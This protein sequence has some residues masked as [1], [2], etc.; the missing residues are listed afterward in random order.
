MRLRISDIYKA[1]TLMLLCSLSSCIGTADIDRPISRQDGMP[2][3][4]IREGTDKA[5]GRVLLMYFE[6]YNNLSFSLEQNLEELEQGYVPE[7]GSKDVMIVYSHTSKSKYDWETP[8]R[9]VIYRLYKH[10]GRT[11]RDTLKTY[12]PSVISVRK[13]MVSDILSTVKQKFPADSYGMLVNS[14][15]TGWLPVHGSI[16]SMSIGAQYGPNH[17]AE[18]NIDVDDFAEAI[19]MR[20][21]YIIF[22]CCLMGG[23]ETTYSLREKA[24]Y[25]VASPTEVLSDGFDYYK[26]AEE[27]LTGPEIDLTSMCRSYYDKHAGG[28]GATI[29]LYDCSVMDELADKCAEVLRGKGEELK[30][31]RP[32]DVQSYNYSFSYHYDFRDIISKVSTPEQCE[33]IDEILSRLVI[34]KNATPVFITTAIDPDKYSGLSMFLPQDSWT[35]LNESYKLTQWNRK[36]HILE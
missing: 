8:T 30:S 7:K 21:D 2:S 9:P 19:P 28:N 4:T 15:A 29:A 12:D 10:Y 27:L 1:L 24:K 18:Y 20:L 11:V 22:D 34:Y 25:I 13:E 31:I 5:F 26:I 6:G 35:D 33:G 36:T 14:H 3:G 17:T 16:E 23:V 32:R